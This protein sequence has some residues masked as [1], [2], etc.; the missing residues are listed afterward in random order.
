[1]KQVGLLDVPPSLSLNST[2]GYIW[3]S[4][5]NSGIILFI[6]Y[7]C[8]HHFVS[9]LDHGVQSRCFLFLVR[10]DYTLCPLRQ[11]STPPEVSFSLTRTN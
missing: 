8:F 9:V 1:M 2:H 3:H 4:I 10:Y 11:H 7:F 6:F 5:V